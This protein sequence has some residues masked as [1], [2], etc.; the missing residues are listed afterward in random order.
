MKNFLS[1]ALVILLVFTT[2][3]PAMASEEISVYFNNEK[4]DFDVPPTIINNR[5]LVPMRHIFEKL[6]AEVE[7]Y[8][9]TGTATATI[10]YRYISITIGSPLMD[11]QRTP[12][13]LDVPAIASDGRILVPLRAISESFESTVKWDESTNSVFVYS[14]DFVDYSQELPEQEVIEVATATELL[15][16][17]GSNKKIILTSDYYNLSD[18]EEFENEFIEKEPSYFENSPGQYTI[19]NVVNMEITGNAE[20]AIDELSVDVLRFENCG[21]ITLSGITAGHT[22]PAEH[23]ECEGA[24]T[25]F[26]YCDNIKIEKCN[27]YGCGAEGIYSQASTNIAVT[28]CKIYDCTYSGIWLTDNSDAKVSKTEFF[29]CDLFGGFLR[30][31]DSQITLDECNIHDMICD[32]QTPFIDSFSSIHLEPAKSYHEVL[33][34]VT[35]NNSTFKNNTFYEISEKYISITFNHCTFEGNNAQINPNEKIFNDCTVK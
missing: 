4:L 18:T 15:K 1:F 24:V 9:E 22:K 26:N 30:I 23:Y 35:I 10:G 8:G 13:E 12:I 33:T 5:V 11:T 3:I 27:L 25:R 19:K 21:K 20:I 29:D 28:D 16:S 34:K 7:W 32:D 14:K 31:D 17:I 2:C 6:G